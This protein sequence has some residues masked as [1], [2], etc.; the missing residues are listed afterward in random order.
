[1]D[2][3]LT[4]RK[5]S[6]EEG[7]SDVGSEIFDAGELGKMLDQMEDDGVDARAARCYSPQA[8]LLD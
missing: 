6:T 2:L 3:Q 4:F 8:I 1:M 7:D 5:V